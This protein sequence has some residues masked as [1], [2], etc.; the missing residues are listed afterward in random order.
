MGAP[1][2]VHV[3]PHNCVDILELADMFDG[4]DDVCVLCALAYGL[5]V[6]P[7]LVWALCGSEPNGPAILEFYGN[8]EGH[9]MGLGAVRPCTHPA[10]F[11]SSFLLLVRGC[12]VR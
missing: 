10:E 4:A 6:A 3:P 1:L 5:A 7:G 12:G 2:L 9:T 8:F 11:V